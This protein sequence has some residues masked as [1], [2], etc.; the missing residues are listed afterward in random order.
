M[1]HATADDW[2]G[3][4][5]SSITPAQ[6][7]SSYRSA[8]LGNKNNT[9]RQPDDAASTVADDETYVPSDIHSEGRGMNIKY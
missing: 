5:L 1:G 7:H 3:T 8:D 9:G 4:L 2:A 6:E